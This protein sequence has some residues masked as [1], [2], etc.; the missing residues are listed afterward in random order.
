VDFGHPAGA[1]SVFF[2]IEEELLY[3]AMYRVAA[4]VLYLVV[5]FFLIPINKLSSVCEGDP[6]CLRN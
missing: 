6:L 4:K 1:I 3:Y 2:Q 5:M